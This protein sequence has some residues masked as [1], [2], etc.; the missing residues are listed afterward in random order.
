MN[1][2]YM[3]PIDEHLKSKS[4]VDEGAKKVL[5]IGCGSGIWWVLDYTRLRHQADD[6]RLVEMAREFPE[7]SFL[8]VDLAPTW[9][10]RVDVPDNAVFELCN[11]VEGITCPDETF[12]VVHCRA[13]MGGV[14]GVPA[15]GK[16]RLMTGTRLG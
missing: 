15:H 1:K 7:V 10:D 13:L 9:D 16:P 6:C 5:D 11:V 8:G 2:N 4:N 3:A 14:S 12:D